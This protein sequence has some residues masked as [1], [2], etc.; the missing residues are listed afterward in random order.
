V[1]GSKARRPTIRS[2]TVCT[3]DDA[4][5]LGEI[6]DDDGTRY[7]FHATAISGGTRTITAGTAVH[8][9]VV[10]APRGRFEADEVTPR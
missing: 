6:E 3:Y 5:G 4:V 9:V 10:F 2:G 1:N 8:F 7:P